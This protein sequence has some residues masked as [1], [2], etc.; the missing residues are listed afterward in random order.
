VHAIRG[1]PTSLSIHI[2]NQQP[3]MSVVFD[4]DY[5][6]GVDVEFTR[7]VVLQDG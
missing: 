3:S 2:E 4:N 1:N 5:L 7:R 6:S